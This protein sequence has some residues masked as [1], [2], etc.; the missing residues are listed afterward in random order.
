[1]TQEFNG[2]VGQV[3]GGNINNYGLHDLTQHNREE[4]A[5]LLVHLRE[6]LR[7]ARKKILMNPIVGWMI[8]G[9]LAFI[10]ELVS[11]SAFGSPLLL[12]ATIFTGMI[13]PYFFFVRIQQKYGPLVYAYRESIT[14]V[15]IFQHS[16][17]WA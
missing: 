9:A 6:R 3:A 2:N 10:V 15:E 16:R 11:G 7:D 4:L 12:F 5:T 14:N 1:M 13:L 8:L 17:G